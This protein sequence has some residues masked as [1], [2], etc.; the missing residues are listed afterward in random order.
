MSYECDFVNL[1]PKLALFAYIGV[2]M[3]HV[4]VLYACE[5]V[6]N[7]WGV[8]CEIRTTLLESAP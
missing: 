8:G 5:G 4:R 3:D 1:I 2:Q 6:K 7:Q